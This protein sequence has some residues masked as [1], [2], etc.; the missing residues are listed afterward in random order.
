MLS[1]FRNTY[2]LIQHDVVS[3][4]CTAPDFLDTVIAL[5]DSTSELRKDLIRQLVSIGCVFVRH[6]GKHDW[7]H[8]P[9]T[10]GSQR[11]PR[12]A[13]INEHLAKRILKIMS[14]P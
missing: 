7:C 9:T 11:V 13:E 5:L 4:L 14:D 12:R 10:K 8:D 6:G 1:W 3:R 2:S